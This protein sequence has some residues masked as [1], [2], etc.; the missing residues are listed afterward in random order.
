M[1]KTIVL[2]SLF[3]LLINIPLGYMREGAKR[4][5]PEKF[6][7]IHASIPLIIAMRI[8]LHLPTIAIPINIAGAVAGQFIGGKIR[9]RSRIPAEPS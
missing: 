9:R 7:W 6:L 4:F 2:L 1:D 3:C 8:M 5:F